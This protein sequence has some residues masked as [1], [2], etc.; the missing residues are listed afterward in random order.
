[1]GNMSR[2]VSRRTSS[3][4]FFWQNLIS[5]RERHCRFSTHF[6]PGQMSSKQSLLRFRTNEAIIRLLAQYSSGAHASRWSSFTI[7]RLDDLLSPSNRSTC[8]PRP[9]RRLSNCRRGWTKRDVVRDELCQ[10]EGG[11]ERPSVSDLCYID[12]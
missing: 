11:Q 7:R 10:D 5:I 9:R 12:L 8:C 2:T 3:S 4:M 6:Q 1:M